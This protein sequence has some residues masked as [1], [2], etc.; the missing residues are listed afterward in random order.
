MR[1]PAARTKQRAAGMK[2]F[3]TL[4]RGW[5]ANEALSDPQPGGAA[6]LENWFPTAT[7]L[8]MRAGSELFAT[9][10]DGSAPVAALFSYVTGT[11]K[12]L[13][14]ASPTQIYDITSVA[15][16]TV[17]PAPAHGP[18]T[19]GDWSVVQFATAGGVFLRGVNGKDTPFVYTADAGF[20]SAPAITG[21]DPTKLS[22]VWSY[23][24]RLF[25]IEKET[26]DAWY[27]PVDQVGGAAVRLPL[28]GVFPLGG[29]LVFGGGWSL[30]TGS[31]LSE[32]CV[33]VT[34]EGEVAVFA[35]DDPSTAAG[36][37]KVGVYRI[38]RPLG[39]KA[40]IRGGGDLIIASDIGFVPLSQ[41]IQRDIAALSPA[42]VSYPIETEWNERVAQRSTVPW[43]CEVW[44]KKQMVAIALPTLVDT[45][46]E[47]LIANARTGAWTLYTG[48]D[49]TCLRAF[50]DRL[51]FGSS[52][53]RIIEAEVTGLDV[54][55]PGQPAIPY[56]ASAVPLFEGL[57]STGVVKTAGLA[58]A[59]LR[60]SVP[61]VARLSAHADYAIEMPSLPDAPMDAIS[62][63]W[64]LGIWG[65]STWGGQ[66][67]KLT[68]Q[69]W[70]SVSAVGS[71]LAPGIQITS[72]SIV[73]P[74][75]ELV[76]LD[77]TYQVGDL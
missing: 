53:G 13:F 57:G 51:F 2:S 36:W 42:A 60:S 55:Q 29:Q 33:F 15:D 40:H 54:G 20:S 25:F 21:A 66:V 38:G 31:G 56:A 5:I 1:L 9:I 44:P 45:R 22:Y 75:V 17:S 72:G 27:L 30:D 28:G 39:P 49:G 70:E 6:L 26:L 59:V 8:R 11:I 69:N 48:W 19:G 50:G 41:A 14:A 63:V 43:H 68:V 52:A 62:S 7:E 76:R 47:M 46:A 10:G 24:R 67:A 71:V 16:P 65:L 73:P 74:R 23:K 32:Q 64:G 18:F 58:R 4:V 12:R 34:S 77:M 61:V 37:Q 35:G 3:P